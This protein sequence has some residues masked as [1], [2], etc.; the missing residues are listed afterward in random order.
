VQRRLATIL[1][2]VLVAI[3]ALGVDVAIAAPAAPAPALP[4]PVPPIIPPVLPVPNPV[5]AA[6]NAVSGAVGDAAGG[7]ARASAQ[8]VLD[9]VARWVSDGA[10]SLLGSL[11]RTIDQNTDPK[12]TKQWFDGHFGL[13]AVVAAQLAIP[14]LFAVAILAIARRDLGLLLRAAFVHAPLALV[15]TGVAMA[16]VGMALSATDELCSYVTKSADVDAAGLLRNLV[17]TL[18]RGGSSVTGFGLVLVSLLIATGGFFLTIELVVR[19]SAIWVAMLFLPLGFVASVWPSTAR[20]GRRL[21]EVMAALILSKFVIVAIVSMAVSA[22]SAGLSRPDVGPLFGGAALL[23]LAAAAPFT[24]LRMVPVV[25]A[26]VVAHL[27]GVGRRAV[28][29]PPAV[30]QVA[31]S[32]IAR[33]LDQRASGGGAPTEPP[34]AIGGEPA[35]TAAA[36]RGR[37]VDGTQAAPDKPVPAASAWRHSV[38][39]VS[40]ATGTP[41][42]VLGATGTAGAAAGPSGA[43]ATG[44]AAAGPSGAAAVAGS[45]HPAAPHPPAPPSIRR[46]DPTSIPPSAGGVG[47]G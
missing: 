47:D 27:E 19:E 33:M 20:W 5:S 1:G 43:A 40:V 25:E 9:A 44:T 17:T 22:T 7:I 36:T 38:R 34:G 8:S 11:A 3:A 32:Q 45:S 28:S 42:A 29:M 46:V 18:S 16:V 10:A 13:M 41:E 14:L 39:V 31:Q 37:D 23:L 6:G 12:D 4:F 21:A 26:S 30:Q 35:P 2:V 24:L 15:G